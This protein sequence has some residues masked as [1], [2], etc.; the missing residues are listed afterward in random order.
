MISFGNRPFGR[1]YRRFRRPRQIGRASAGLGSAF[2]FQTTMNPP[3]NRNITPKVGFSLVKLPFI[4]MWIEI[5][6][7]N[8][9]EV[10]HSPDSVPQNKQ[11]EKT[12]KFGGTA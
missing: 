3:Q 7:R 1:N 4:E 5:T 6:D 9:I 8:T 12:G 10:L 2:S 11:P